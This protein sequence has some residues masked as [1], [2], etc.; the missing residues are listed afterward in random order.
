MTLSG[1]DPEWT[2]LEAG[3]KPA[4]RIAVRPADAHRLAAGLRA[5]GAAVVL[6]QSRIRL[7]RR[8]PE[9]ILYVAR[10]D[11]SAEHI[12]DVENATLPSADAGSGTRSDAHRELG[13]LLGYPRCCVDAFLTTTA[14]FDDPEGARQAIIEDVLHARAASAATRTHPRARVNALLIG[15]RVRLVTFYPC[16]YDCGAAL[17]Y[18]DALHAALAR[19]DAVAAEALDRALACT[20]ALGPD[21]A[22]ALLI[23]GDDGRQHAETPPRPSGMRDERGDAR[24]ATMLNHALTGGTIPDAVLVIAFSHAG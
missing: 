17:A 2:A 15:S 21:G 3:L 19:K 6:S 20:I 16:S 22:R 1:P 7:G 9:T 4:V 10:S 8:E 5:R 14:V 23:A 11:A 24:F 13:L 18:A 12:R